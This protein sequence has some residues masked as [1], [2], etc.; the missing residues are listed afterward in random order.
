MLQVLFIEKMLEDIKVF[1]EYFDEDFFAYKED[2]DLDWRAQL[3]GWKCVYT[4]YA[5]AYHIRGGTTNTVSKFVKQMMIFR[6]RYLMMLKNDTLAG[7]LKDFS[8]LLF[9]EAD[10]LHRIFVEKSFL[11]KNIVEIFILT[12]KMLKKEG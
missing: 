1:D 2:V 5:I 8:Y 6:N 12:P 9:T 3:R 11:L 4:P 7:I 10:T